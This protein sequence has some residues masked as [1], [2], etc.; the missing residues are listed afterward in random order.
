MSVTGI[1]IYEGDGNLDWGALRKHGVR[2]AWQKVNE[3]DLID[4]TATVERVK[5][6]RHAGVLIGG[7]NFLRPRPGRTG[8]QEF[9]IFYEHAREVGLLT[10]GSLRPCLDVEAS[11]YDLD[12]RT[13]RLHTRRYVRSWVRRAGEHG[14]HPIVYSAA[15]FWD[16]G[17]RC[18]ST[19]DCPLWVAAYTP[20]WRTS[21]P[22][23]WHG[24]ASFHQWTDQAVMPGAAHKLDC[25]RYLSGY[26]QLIRRHTI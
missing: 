6:A 22:R 23:A 2:F 9:D 24:H 17:M 21:I 1:D 7:Y 15:W 8:A 19:F 25:N 26:T 11:G 5:A 14:L 10:R 18:R 13:G 20:N 4:S 3:G 12:T 16:D